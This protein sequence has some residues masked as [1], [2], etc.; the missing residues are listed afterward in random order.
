MIGE[1]F[2]LESALAS[3][4]GA[5]DTAPVWPVEGDEGGKGAG[6]VVSL[7]KDVVAPVIGGDDAVA[8]S[9]EIVD[10]DARNE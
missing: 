8:E 2:E 7:A 3:D 4:E 1:G 5:T 10:V 6:E 9:C